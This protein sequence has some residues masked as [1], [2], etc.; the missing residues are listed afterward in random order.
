MRQRLTYKDEPFILTSKDKKAKITP[1]MDITKINY[2][3]AT[4][5][6]SMIF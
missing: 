4:K 6:F 2:D 5:M 3:I 1:Q